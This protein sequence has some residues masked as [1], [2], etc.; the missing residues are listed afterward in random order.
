MADVAQQAFLATQATRFAELERLID[1]V[2]MVDGRTRHQSQTAAGVALELATAAGMSDDAARSLRIAGLLHDVGKSELP[3]ELLAPSRELSSEEE[4]ALRSHVEIGE[5]LIEAMPR[6]DEV[7]QG[8]A[9]HHEHFDGSGY[10]RGLA[11]ADIPI[12]GRI[13]AIAAG[14]AEWR[15]R[16]LSAEEAVARVEAEAGRLYDPELLAHL[17]DVLVGE[18]DVAA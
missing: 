7:L 15:A 9:N 1:E 5:R 18:Q 14:Y 3:A 4:E 10:P 6:L 17:S 11:G 2:D 8:V 13:M 16:G 12:L